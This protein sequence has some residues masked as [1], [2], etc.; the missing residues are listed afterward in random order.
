MAKKSTGQVALQPR[1]A[2]TTDL[3]PKALIGT[4]HQTNTSRLVWQPG[5]WYLLLLWSMYLLNTVYAT[6]LDFASLSAFVLSISVSGGS[7]F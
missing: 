2:V 1:Q 6:F 4:V 5:T 3:Q 7:D